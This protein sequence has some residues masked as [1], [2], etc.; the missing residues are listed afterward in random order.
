MFEGRGGDYRK[1]ERQE[2]ERV[3][4]HGR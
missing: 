2:E 3:R 4:S 1:K